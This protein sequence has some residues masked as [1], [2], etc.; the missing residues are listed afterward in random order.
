[1]KR[2]HQNPRLYWGLAILF[3][4]VYLFTP[5]SIYNR[6]TVGWAEDPGSGTRGF[7][8]ASNPTDD[9]DDDGLTNE[10]EAALG[11]DPNNPD[12]DGDG[13]ID[14]G[15]PSVLARVLPPDSAFKDSD[16]G[17]RKAMLARL[18]GI[19]DHML[20]GDI[21]QALTAL[22]NLQRRVDGCPPKAK[23][24]DWIVDCTE[25]LRV[26]ALIE[27]LISNH[28]SYAIDDST[29]PSV[30][31]IPG[32]SGGP[33]RPVGVAV[34]PDGEPEEFVVNEVIFKPENL[35][36]LYDF[37]ATYD[38]TVLHD[39]TPRLIDGATPT[40]DLPASTG[41]YL[42]RVDTALSQ[43]DDIAPNMEA[44]GLRGS[45]SFSSEEAARLAALVARETGRQVS[46]NFLT[47]LAQSCTVCEHPLVGGGN[48]DAA[49]WWWMT[50]DDDP[51]TPGDQ[52]LSIGVIH[53][54]EYLRY[55]GY[56]PMAPYVPVTVAVIDTGFDLDETTG[57]PLNGNLDYSWYRSRP[58]QLD[59]I[60]YD[61]TAGG[62]GYALGCDGC[63]H[64]QVS[65]GACCAYSRNLFGSA[66]TSGGQIRPIL[67]KIG[68][69]VH[70][71]A[72][73][74]Y[75]A[76]YNNA[77]VI[78]MSVCFE[79][80]SFCHLVYDANMLKAVLIGAKNIGSIVV[81]AAGNAGDDISDN[82]RI[83]CELDGA[84]CVGAM[85][86]NLKARKSS[87]FGSVVDMWAPNGILSTVTRNSAASDGN[88][89]DL[90][91]DELH[92]AFG[93]SVSSPYLAGIVA[94]MKMLDNSIPYYKV[95]S[96]LQSTANTSPDAKVSPGYV[97]AYRAVEK[98]KPN[99]PPTVKITKPIDGASTSY[100]NVAFEA[101]VTDPE[102]LSGPYAS[103]FESTV[104]FYDLP[105]GPLCTSTGVGPALACT[106]PQMNPGTYV[107]AAKA[108]DAFGATA[109]SNFI[110]ITVTNQPPKAFVTYPPDSSTFYTSQKINL[111]GYA[112]DPDPDEVLPGAA[113]TWN[114]NIDGVLGTG[115]DISVS[116]QAG[117]HTITLKAVDPLGAAG[118]ASITL[119]V[120]AGAGYPTAYITQPQ[121]NAV[122]ALGEPI[123]FEGEGIDPEDGKLTGSS[124]EWKSDIDGFLGTG[125]TITVILSGVQ[126]QTVV[127]NVSLK[128]TDS[129][130]HEA[131]DS[132]R[133]Q[134][135]HHF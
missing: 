54:W 9:D 30:P 73:G 125:D 98:V 61:W 109:V 112:Y 134:V 66:G 40:P 57:L 84:I 89:D 64:G 35:T 110:T 123:T 42:I 122:F 39:G 106:V 59:E 3:F 28:F 79:C 48:A 7:A 133:V 83:P 25:Q 29:V 10:E 2:Q 100:L 38:G 81:A 52:G 124:L 43:L 94:L 96:I 111:R 95:L 12:T 88:V 1:M 53:A 120:Q 118:T 49:K 27:T 131:T 119:Y 101:E 58:P 86:R 127:H 46:A 121:N 56:P 126:Y 115:P 55:K 41:W 67:I 92:E 34:D 44:A 82:H 60:D 47:R 103:Q 6:L 45:W 19:E 16:A 77:D 132:I 116:L 50:E 31:E 33:P 71:A 105:A 23:K 129:D 135:M 91:E 108:T 24:D 107:I 97:D 113:L 87:N 104:A 80:G 90:G 117:T 32:P 65:F 76:L 13:I 18:D 5:H 102:L 26:R 93:T 114:S 85:D 68:Y 69:D 36:D 62:P 51:S 4:G 37:L 11:T 15:D 21:E 128:V 8:L 74:V 14:G 78:N 72:I 22:E 75:D 70:S 99:Q 63:W 17:L 130:G 20:A